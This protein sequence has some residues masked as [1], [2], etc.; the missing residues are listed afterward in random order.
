MARSE[1]ELSDEAAL[2]QSEA[3]VHWCRRVGPP[4]PLAFARWAVSKD[5]G[6]MDRLAVWARVRRIVNVDPG[7]A[8]GSRP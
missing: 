6:P 7:A 3:F 1:H 2:Y 8:R 5:L 4:V